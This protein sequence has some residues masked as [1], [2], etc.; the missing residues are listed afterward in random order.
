MQPIR[1]GIFGTKAIVQQLG[2][3]VAES[4]DHRRAAGG[5]VVVEL[6]AGAIEIGAVVEAFQP[7]Q[8]VLRISE[9]RLNMSAGQ[10]P[11]AADSE[12]DLGVASGQLE[13]YT[14]ARALET[15]ISCW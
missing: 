8:N 15:A 4:I 14:L 5:G 12:D 10:K 7:R 6:G 11:R 13:G 9:Q 1:L 3:L 2:A